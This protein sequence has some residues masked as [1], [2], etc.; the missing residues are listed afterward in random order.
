MNSNYRYNV[1]LKELTVICGIRREL[2]THLARHTF[3][4]IMLNSGVPLEDVSKMLGHRNIRTTQR[5]A[6]VRKNR[7][8]ENI[9]KVRGKLK[10]VA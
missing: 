2:N 7:I 1:Y 10:A 6:R 9:A 3:A 8:S 4:D 5:Y